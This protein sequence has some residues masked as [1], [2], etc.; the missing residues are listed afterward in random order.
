[1]ERV[2]RTISNSLALMFGFNPRQRAL[3][4]LLGVAGLVTLNW[5][6]AATLSILAGNADWGSVELW[7]ALLG[8]PAV[9][10]IFV[11]AS[12]QAWRVQGPNAA[13]PLSMDQRPTPSEGVILFLSTYTTFADKLPPAR[14]DQIWR[15][16]DLVKALEEPECDWQCILDHVQASN[17]Q[18]P[19]EAIQYHANAGKLRHVW[20][21]TT[22]DT[23]DPDPRK[24]PRPGSKHLAQAFETVAKDVIERRVHFHHSEGELVV[25]ARD[26]QGSFD[27]V[28]RIYSQEAPRFNLKDH[29]LIADFTSGTVNM[30]AGM[31]LAC[32]LYGRK[33]QFTTSERDPHEDKPLTQPIPY[34]VTIDEAAL[35]RQI[36]RY[37]ADLPTV[38]ATDPE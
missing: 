5:F 32:V 12:V 29:D 34:A 28:N 33:L 10:I 25:D 26:I 17:M 6:S 11:L 24:P 1:L 7:V 8:L 21:I 13:R 16:D 9:F 22:A 31:L 14:R 2:L 30:S 23:P 3:A 18:V 20:L 36:L 4:V 37:M 27:A 38:Q 19:L 35:R 15:G